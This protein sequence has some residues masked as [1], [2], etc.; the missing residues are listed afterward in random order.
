MTESLSKYLQG[1]LSHKIGDADCH[2]YQVTSE[3]QKHVTYDLQALQ[4]KQLQQRD[5]LTDNGIAELDNLIVDEKARLIAGTSTLQ[6]VA[7]L[8]AAKQTLVVAK[9]GLEQQ[10]AVIVLPPF[11]GERLDSLLT[12]ANA[13]NLEEQQ[14]LAQQSKYQNWDVTVTVGEGSNPAYPLLHTLPNQTFATAQFTYSFGAAK[15]DRALDRA[16]SSYVTATNTAP[17]GPINLANLLRIQVTQARDAAE[18]SYAP[19]QTYDASLNDQLQSIAN[20]DTAVARAF[21]IQLMI[22]QVS[23]NIELMSDKYAQVVMDTY[24]AQNFSNQ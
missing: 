22:A 24:L 13:Y 5:A 3:I 18:L 21:R 14:T 11:D 16:A 23:N 12:L 20:I 1:H 19:Y 7:M 2:L 6:N 10:I 4:L 15:R 9:T 8:E 17:T